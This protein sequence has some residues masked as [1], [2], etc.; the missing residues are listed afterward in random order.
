MKLKRFAAAAVAG[1]MCFALAG[2]DKKTDSDSSTSS[3]DSTSS[4]AQTT[5]DSSKGGD[6]YLK[7][8]GFAALGDNVKMVSSFDD[9]IKESHKLVQNGID[10]NDE[11]LVRRIATV[12][13]ITFKD[14]GSFESL[15]APNVDTYIQYSGKYEQKDGQISF[16]YEHEKIVRDNGKVD[17]DDAGG[18]TGMGGTMQLYNS[19]GE[20]TFYQYAYPN[21]YRADYIKF[22]MACMPML[23]GYVRAT[24][25]I[26]GEPDLLEKQKKQYFT[27]HDGVL[28]SD[29][30]GVTLKGDYSKGNDFALEFDQYK[31]L[32]EW[33]FETNDQKDALRYSL[34]DKTGKGSPTTIE[35]SSN[36]WTWKNAEGE[37]INSGSYKE[38]D[39]I[40][41]LFV[42]NTD[43]S[44][45]HGA[46]DINLYQFMYINGGEVYFPYAFKA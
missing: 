21:W 31:M 29:T 37:T 8:E 26:S 2:C 30:V 44:S 7:L 18:D 9:A 36:K 24:P 10:Y 3:A 25:I 28:C 41:G 27:L 43:D 20:G 15:I 45:Q 16:S 19:K 38:S 33:A 12:T 46:G 13:E 22:D 40:E 23:A 34:E 39:E 14:D 6:I 17:E 1:A 5:S 4:A 35:F 42:M 11:D 32:D